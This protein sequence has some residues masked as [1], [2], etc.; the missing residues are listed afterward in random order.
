M[1][2]IAPTYPS[3]WSIPSQTNP[4]LE[5]QRRILLR[6][7]RA[8]LQTTSAVNHAFQHVRSY[9]GL[10]WVM[11]RS[12]F[13]EGHGIC[14]RGISWEYVMKLTSYVIIDS[15]TSPQIISPPFLLLPANAPYLSQI[16]PSF[17]LPAANPTYD[18]SGLSHASYTQPTASIILPQHGRNQGYGDCGE[19]LPLAVVANISRTWPTEISALTASTI[20]LCGI[21]SIAEDGSVGWSIWLK[22][23]CQNCRSLMQQVPGIGRVLAGY[24]RSNGVC[25]KVEKQGESVAGEEH[26][27]APLTYCRFSYSDVYSADRA[28]IYEMLEHW[29]LRNKGLVWQADVRMHLATMWHEFIVPYR[30]TPSFLLYRPFSF[31]SKSMGPNH[32]AVTQAES[33]VST[34]LETSTQS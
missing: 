22:A 30:Y 18:P 10:Q 16:T 6:E 7:L 5:I 2:S 21:R 11:V 17:V 13:G 19:T 1:A 25:W 33:S 20:N 15:S 27:P 14:R 4:L 34:H 29:T 32:F 23:P 26:R 12:G 9:S 8:R 3:N 24:G 28:G 31:P